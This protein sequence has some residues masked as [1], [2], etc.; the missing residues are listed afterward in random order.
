MKWELFRP[1]LPPFIR[2]MLKC[3][4]THFKLGR[5]PLHSIIF[6][7]CKDT[8]Q[9]PQ[10]LQVTYQGALSLSKYLLVVVIYVCVSFYVIFKPC[11]YSIY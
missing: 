4:L 5:S 11:K 2:S 10:Q 7:L 3:H 1:F 9:H 8:L 6:L